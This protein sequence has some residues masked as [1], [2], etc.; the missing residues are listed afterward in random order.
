MTNPAA[1]GFDSARQLLRHSLATLAYRGSKAMR[2]AAEDFSSFSPGGGCRSAGA[3]LTH[4]GD[5]LDW[6]LS[7]ANGERAWHTSEPQSWEEDVTSF[8]AALA[9]FDAYLASDQPLHVSAEK[10]FRDRS[11][12][13]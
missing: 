7:L 11:R 9:A 13:L 8:H 3:I 5:L 6:G 10:L 1:S 2:G 12:M 4:L